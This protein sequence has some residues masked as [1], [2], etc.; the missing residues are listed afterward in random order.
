MY[1]LLLL[2]D[3]T[4]YTSITSL[5]VNVLASQKYIYIIIYLKL[6]SINEF[7]VIIMQENYL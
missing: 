2:H 7:K 1:R 5:P 3:D 4:V 6:I